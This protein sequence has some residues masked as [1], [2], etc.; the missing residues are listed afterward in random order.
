MQNRRNLKSQYPVRN[1]VTCAA[2]ALVALLAGCGT[3]PTPAPNVAP[4]NNNG[5]QSGGVNNGTGCAYG[6]LYSAQYNQCLYTQGC[7][8]GWAIPPTTQ[9][10]VQQNCIPV[11]VAGAGT[12][13]PGSSTSCTAGQVWST[14]YGVC[15]TPSSACTAGTAWYVNQCIPL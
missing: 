10:G 4:V 8:A 11:T 6:Q 13:G 14:S 9:P 7:A 12:S 3:N 2:A 15:A 1:F 5:V